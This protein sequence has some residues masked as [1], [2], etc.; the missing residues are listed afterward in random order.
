MNKKIILAII[1]L[2]VVLS[3]MLIVIFYSKTKIGASCN[4]NET[5]QNI[6]CS[7]YDTPIKEGYKPFCVNNQ[8][9]CMCYGCE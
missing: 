3:I 5:C 6:D 2:V 7:S 1:I 4:L 8:C 9:R